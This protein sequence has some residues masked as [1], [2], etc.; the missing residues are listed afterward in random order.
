MKVQQQQEF[1]KNIE[2]T[3]NHFNFTW[4]SSSAG[5]MVLFRC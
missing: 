1:F 3:N 4:P 2:I 5:W